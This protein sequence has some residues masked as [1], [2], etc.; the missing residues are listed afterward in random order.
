MAE[1]P[2]TEPFADDDP[3]APF[4]G[5]ELAAEAF[6]AGTRIPSTG[7][8]SFYDRLRERILRGVQRR[9]SRLGE[10][11]VEVLLLVP[12]IFILLVR[13]AL[14]RDVPAST[15]ALIGGALAYFLLP[16]DL[17]PE[18]FL[19][20]AGYVD[21]VVLATA[22]LAKAFGDELDSYARKH[23][24]G[25]QELRQVLADVTGAARALVGDSVYRRLKAFLA[26]RGVELGEE[27]L[28]GAGDE[29]AGT[30]SATSNGNGASGSSGHPA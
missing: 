23:W 7:L 10:G 1:D 5:D 25:P 13:L 9:G 26:R 22:V 27:S 4:H 6:D 8:L 24:S 21:D 12:D 18:A 15:R 17:L 30:G 20:V 16:V 14:D 11:T 19:G 29:V 3:A 2:R 28:G